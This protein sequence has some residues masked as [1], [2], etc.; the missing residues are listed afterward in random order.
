MSIR[1][2]QEEERQE[3]G[4]H[5]EGCEQPLAAEP[6]TEV[7]R[8]AEIINTVRILQERGELWRLVG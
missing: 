2:E 7:E 6:P 4:L 1:R 3:E 5:V 8:N